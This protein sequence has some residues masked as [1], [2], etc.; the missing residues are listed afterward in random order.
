T[1]SE[2]RLISVYFHDNASLGLDV[3]YD[4]AVFGGN[5][6]EFALYSHLVQGNEGI[7]M[8]IQTVNSVDIS[9]VVIPLGVNVSQGLEVRFSVADMALPSSVNI[10]LEDTIANTLTLL[11][12]SDYVI[13]TSTELSE[14]GRFF[15]RVTES[16]LSTTQNDLDTLNVF[17]INHSK[18]LIVRGQ[19]QE[20]TKLVLYD[21]QGRKVLSLELDSSIFENRID[22]SPL[23]GGAYIINLQNEMWGKSKKIVID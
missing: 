7:P 17:V 18:E 19:L 9:D 10:Y 21:L 5:V 1:L 16:I 4:A 13:S 20:S 8:A 3:G 12:N 14:T 23:N 2:S 15:L 22:I 11:T 6:T